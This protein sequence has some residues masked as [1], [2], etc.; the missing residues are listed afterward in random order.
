MSSVRDI[1][2]VLFVLGKYTYSPSGSG[3]SVVIL[4]STVVNSLFVTGIIERII[5]K[6]ISTTKEGIDL[7]LNMDNRIG[8]ITAI[9]TKIVNGHNC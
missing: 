1:L 6:N 5:P 2:E 3:L 9:P 4:P 8:I 7:I